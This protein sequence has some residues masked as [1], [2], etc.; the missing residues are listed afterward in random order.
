[1]ANSS[2]AGNR[3]SENGGPEGRPTLSLENQLWLEE[4]T[5]DLP[6]HRP[7]E[8]QLVPIGGQGPSVCRTSG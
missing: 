5:S 3:R 7:E 4:G 6:G 8:G 1:M 2:P